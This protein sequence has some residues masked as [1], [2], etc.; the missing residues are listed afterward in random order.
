MELI[1]NVDYYIEDGKYIMTA[2][3]LS[4][5]GVC[6]EHGCRHCPYKSKTSLDLQS[7]TLSGTISSYEE[8]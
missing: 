4:K 7:K 1:E 5:T 8:K 2:A 3:F 6:C